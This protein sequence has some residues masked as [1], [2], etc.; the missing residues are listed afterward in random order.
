MRIRVSMVNLM[1]VFR[2]KVEKEAAPETLLI[3]EEIPEP[4][5]KTG[6]EEQLPAEKDNVEQEESD[7]KM[8]VKEAEKSAPEDSEDK[9]EVNDV[10][11]YSII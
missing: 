1:F 3:K 11:T 10:S 2:L 4:S 9:V 6:P 7:G 5:V 8:D